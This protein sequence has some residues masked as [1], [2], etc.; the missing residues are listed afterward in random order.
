MSILK[1]NR[2]YNRPAFFV[3]VACGSANVHWAHYNDA[4]RDTLWKAP[5]RSLIAMS[6]GQVLISRPLAHVVTP[7][8]IS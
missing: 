1:V 7:P 2:N 5:E 8:H 3:A 4:P 6:N